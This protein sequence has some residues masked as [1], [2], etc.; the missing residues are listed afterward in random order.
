MND[1]EKENGIICS[2]CLCDE[3]EMDMDVELGL[4]PHKFHRQCI[5]KWFETCAE[6][7][8]PFTCPCCARL[9]TPADLNQMVIIMNISVLRFQLNKSNKTKN[10][11]YNAV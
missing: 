3:T 7:N 1:S 4:C 9:I 6:A 8:R 2:I 5:T 10:C 11:G